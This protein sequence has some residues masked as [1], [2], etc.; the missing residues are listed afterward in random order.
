MKQKLHRLLNT[1]LVE[2]GFELLRFP[3]G[4]LKKRIELLRKYK[5][6]FVFDVGANTGQYASQLRRAG[7]KGEILS[8]EPLNEAFAALRKKTDQDNLWNAVQMGLGDFDGEAVIHVAENSVS[9]SIRDIKN[10]HVQA[11]PKSKYIAQET[12]TVRK[13][14]T[15]FHEYKKEGKT[16]FLK[17]DT[18]GFE[19]EVINGALQSLSAFAG[20]QVEMS[21][22]PLYEGESMYEELK[23][24]IEQNG[25]ELFSLEPG[26]SDPGTGK[27]MQVDGVFFRKSIK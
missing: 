2:I 11:V 14:D 15:V 3:N 25:F 4:L 21:L 24:L 17:I 12:I 7:Y 20:I 18:Q 23:K 13:L 16:C 8:F 26:F 1:I 27:L 6:D 9:S 19:K 10:E 5:V 22:V